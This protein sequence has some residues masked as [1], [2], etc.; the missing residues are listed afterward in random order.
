MKALEQRRDLKKHLNKSSHWISFPFFTF[1]CK[2]IEFILQMQI[3]KK[4]WFAGFPKV[5]IWN[6]YS[7]K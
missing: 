7:G 4:Q 5:L 2:K 1:I 6:A 3:N